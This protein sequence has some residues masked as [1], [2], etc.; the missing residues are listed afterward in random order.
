M[1][2]A[3]LFVVNE[4]WEKVIGYCSGCSR[5]GAC[6]ALTGHSS[7]LMEINLCTK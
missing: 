5:K 3:L 7:L 4:S 1:K 6:V 2:S